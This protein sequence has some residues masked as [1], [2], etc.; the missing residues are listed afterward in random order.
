[1]LHSCAKIFTNIGII[2]VLEIKDLISILSFIGI[3]GSE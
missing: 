1:M 3:Y 2:N